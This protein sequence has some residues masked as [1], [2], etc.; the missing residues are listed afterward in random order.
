MRPSSVLLV[1]LSLLF[2]SCSDDDS[3]PAVVDDFSNLTLVTTIENDA[4]L[5]SLYTTSGQLQAGHNHIYVNLVDKTSDA[6]LTN[7]QMSWQPLMQMTS[8]SH[9]C[10][11]SALIPAADKQA[12]YSGSIV[13]QMA[14]M[15]NDFW[16]LNLEYE[17]NGQTFTASGA[18]HVFE[19]DHR[20]VQV[21]TGTDNEKYVLAM[22]SPTA[23]VTGTNE[24]RA[25]VHRVVS[26]MNYMAVNDYK[27]EI[28][29][30]MPAMN[31]HGSPGNIALEQNQ[32]GGDYIGSLTL[33]MT[34][35]WRINL[36]LKNSANELLYGNPV[37]DQDP[38]SPLYFDLTF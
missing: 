9:S 11:Y 4:H 28:D 20:R 22:I 30:R 10:P 17:I 37:T 31:N 38:G 7:A 14:T 36:Q 34:G 24:M 32:A 8:M 5:I 19:P 12:M 13:F 16:T 18:I 29:P 6:R 33:T 25:S 35:Y 3:S 26:A 2:F 21:V 15:A 1:L 23:P 27:I